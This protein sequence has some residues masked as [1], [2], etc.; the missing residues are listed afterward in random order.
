MS[1]NRMHRSAGYWLGWGLGALAIAFLLLDAS[2]KLLALPVV[3]QASAAIGFEGAVMARTLGVI[4]ALCT[5][6][7][8]IPRTAL[9]GA[10]LLTGYLGGSVAAQLRVGNP[11]FTNVLF[12]VYVGGMIWGA[13]Y[14]RDPMLRALFL[15]RTRDRD[16]SRP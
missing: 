2:M 8:A 7:Y 9:L 15:S 13:L 1:D 11:L 6:L 12:G 10:V 16:A 3:L 4:L 14:L 5:I